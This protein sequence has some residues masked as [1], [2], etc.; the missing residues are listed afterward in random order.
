MIKDIFGGLMRSELSI[1]KSKK[2]SVT[3][4]PFFMLNL[5]L[6]REESVE[7]CLDAFFADKKL[8]DYKVDGVEVRAT[9]LH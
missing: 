6:V 2:V 3:Y 5:E 4:E 9:Q 7:S 1:E 8:E